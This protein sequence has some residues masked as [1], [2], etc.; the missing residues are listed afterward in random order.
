[1]CAAHE[2]LW[3]AFLLLKAKAVNELSEAD[4]VLFWEHVLTRAQLRLADLAEERAFRAAQGA[5]TVDTE[6]VSA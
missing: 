4:E 6:A 2:A 5:R 3:L 1:M